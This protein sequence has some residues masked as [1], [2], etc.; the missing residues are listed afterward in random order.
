MLNLKGHFSS[1]FWGYGNKEEFDIYNAVIRYERAQ[2]SQISLLDQQFASVDTF[3]ED[4]Y[5]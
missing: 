4:L 2:F 3:S 1:W 5:E